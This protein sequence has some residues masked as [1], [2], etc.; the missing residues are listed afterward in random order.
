VNDPEDTFFSRTDSTAAP[1][2][3]HAE[4]LEQFEH[5]VRVGATRTRTSP[6]EVLC[7]A[8]RDTLAVD[9]AT[10]C[11]FHGTHVSVPVA[12]TS[13]R[14]DRAEDIQFTLGEG[15]G[16]H[17]GARDRELIP[18]LKSA[19]VT[20]VW[21]FY[22]AALLGMTPYQAVFSFPLCLSG[23]PL[24]VLKLY[25]RVTGPLAEVGLATEMA[26]RVA[27]KLLLEVGT[28]RGEL[29]WLQD[30][31]QCRRGPVWQAQSLVMRLNRLSFDDAL[32]FLRACSITQG[33]LVPRLAADIVN[34]LVPVPVL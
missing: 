16:L 33:V 6:A 22:S 10:I 20:R 3:A 26:R 28:G 32:D 8:V 13:H 1:T 11:V 24:G 25:R 21:P 5:L 9:A 29:K 15:P 30:P 4:R 34:G 2:H 23:P 27:R 7:S 31:A 14:A 19:E 17:V 18:D 12:G